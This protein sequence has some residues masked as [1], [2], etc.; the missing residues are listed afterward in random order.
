MK[1][2]KLMWLGLALLGCED[3]LKTVEL[4]EEPR[5]LGG[6]VEVMGAAERAAPA[7][8]ETATATFLLAAPAAEQSLGFHLAACPAAAREGTRNACA[9]PIFAEKASKNGEA[10][11]ASLTFTVPQDLDAS[12]RVL[13]AGIVCPDGSPTANGE[14]C[15]GADPGTPLQLELELAHDGDVNRNP[16]L[17]ADSIAFDG[18]AWATATAT[19]GACTG[20]GLPEVAQ[21]S[22]HDLVV[23]LD[24]SDRDTLPRPS[25]LD[26][27]R[28]SLQLSHFVTGGDVTRAFESI[29]WDSPQ[30]H[31]QVS[32]TAPKQSGLVRFWFVLRDLRGGGDFVERAVCVQ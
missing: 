3:P 25:K 11:V 15:D 31:R 6:R 5:L 12:G 29:A 17:Q 10:D 28:E 19:D 24:E 2:L 20:L 16:V 7:P 14:A 21:D 22:K 1:N 30:L 18:A 23:E 8:G 27:A 4:V 9:G 32:W 13:V 26:P